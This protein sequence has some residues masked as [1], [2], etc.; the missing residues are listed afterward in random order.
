MALF[1][2]E[3]HRGVPQFGNKSHLSGNGKPEV[4]SV[5]LADG[6][7]AC[8]IVGLPRVNESGDR[9]C[10]WPLKVV[11]ERQAGKKVQIGVNSIV[12]DKI[13]LERTKASGHAK[14]CMVFKL[15]GQAHWR[16]H[17]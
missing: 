15:Q 2:E 12:L 6:S 16:L 4:Q 17:P 7:T 14:G 11:D 13:N 10:S 8:D 1:N 3:R 5:H 9:E